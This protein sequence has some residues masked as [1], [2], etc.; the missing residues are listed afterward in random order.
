MSDSDNIQI[1]DIQYSVSA[2]LIFVGATKQRDL[3]HTEVCH[4]IAYYSNTYN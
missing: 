4:I 3:L 1:Q 2:S